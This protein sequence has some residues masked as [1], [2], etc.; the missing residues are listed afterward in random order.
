VVWVIFPT[1]K[2]VEVYRSLRD[3]SICFDS[4]ICSAAPVL[5]DFQI[6][7]DKLL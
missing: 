2:K 1:L 4:D 6:S 5:P 3:I 7:V